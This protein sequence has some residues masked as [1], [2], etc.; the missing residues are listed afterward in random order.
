MK[1]GTKHAS[2]NFGDRK[3][4]R[5]WEK[6]F[7]RLA[8]D[9]GYSFLPLQI[10]RDD[11][12]SS[13]YGPSQDG[14]F[15]RILTPDVQVFAVGTEHHEIKHKNPTRRQEY[16]LERYRLEQL[17]DFV[18]ETKHRVL[19]TI[20]DW[21]QAGASNGRE[22]VANH[23]EHWRTIDIVA[24]SKLPRRVDENGLSYCDGKSKTTEI[25]YWPT[26]Y[27][28]PLQHYWEFGTSVNTSYIGFEERF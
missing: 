25:W 13:A 22:E 23:I 27:W 6:R 8:K 11:G 19:Y 3:L 20:H 2:D 16:G 14:G 1:Q 28:V 7:C 5:L 9:H 26:Y 24:L 10:G 15:R 21:E 17:L 4:G 12:A 18:S